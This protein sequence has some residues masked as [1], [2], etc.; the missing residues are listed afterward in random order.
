M[1]KITKIE[2]IK[3]IQDKNI[4]PYIRN[5]IE[6]ILVEYKDYSPNGSI[7]A[8]GGIYFVESKIDL[9]SIESKLSINVNKNRFE[10]IE[11]VD[12]GYVDACV[13]INNE[14]AI[15]IIGKRELFVEFME[16]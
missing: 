16:D 1:I 13:V 5:L 3:Q 4:I 8:V 2:N 15:N 11:K 6:Q 10:W 14:K 12:Y 7:E 9:Y